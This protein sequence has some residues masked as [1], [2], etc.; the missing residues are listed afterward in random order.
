MFQFK[1]AAHVIDVSVSDE[2]LP[3]PEPVFIQAALDPA[4]LVAGIDDDR[5]ARLLVPK[6]GAVALQRANGEGFAQDQRIT[7]SRNHPI[8]FGILRCVE[9]HSAIFIFHAAPFFSFACA[10]RRAEQ[11]T[12][13]PQSGGSL[14]APASGIR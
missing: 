5:L 12:N 2:N 8:K 13:S 11:P 6:D 1:C 14:K 9:V 4:D 7:L 3:E 10:G